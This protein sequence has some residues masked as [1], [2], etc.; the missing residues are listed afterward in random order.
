MP[1]IRVQTPSLA[2]LRRQD[3]AKTLDDLRNVVEKISK[4]R[5][6]QAKVSGES[7]PSGFMTQMDVARRAREGT[8][9]PRLASMLPSTA[10]KA[11]AD[12][13]AWGGEIA[14]ET[15]IGPLALIPAAGYDIVKSLSPAVLEAMSRLPGPSMEALAIDERTS[16]P[17]PIENI[18][19]LVSGYR[20][21]RPQRSK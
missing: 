1:A 7:N 21:Y 4:I 19:A 6:L 18:M 16:P 15:G 9:D 2:E 13:Y 8:P 14:K 10:E 11:L 12:R 20:N 17:N 3:S 5:E